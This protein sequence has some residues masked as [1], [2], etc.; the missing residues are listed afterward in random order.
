MILNVTSNI[1]CNDP[2]ESKKPQISQ[3]SGTEA[4]MLSPKFYKIHAF[5]FASKFNT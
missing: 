1:I 3:D 2:I 4:G 5:I